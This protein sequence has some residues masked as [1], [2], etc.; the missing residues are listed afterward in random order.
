MPKLLNWR[1]LLCRPHGRELRAGEE[2][3]IVSAA[4][5]AGPAVVRGVGRALGAGLRQALFARVPVLLGLL[6]LLH[7]DHVGTAAAAGV[8]LLPGA[9]GGAR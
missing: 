8:V 4:G 3:L 5:A 7:D 9:L 2:V 1:L 6:A